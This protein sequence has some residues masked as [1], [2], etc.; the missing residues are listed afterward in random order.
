MIE[1]CLTEFCRRY[2][3]H[4]SQM[5]K[6]KQNIDHILVIKLESRYRGESDTLEY[7]GVVVGA[8]VGKCLPG[9]EGL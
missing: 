7:S 4:F 2:T 3:L 9:H 6:N 1:V 8:G 5:R